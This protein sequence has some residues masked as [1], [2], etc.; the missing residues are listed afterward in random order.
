MITGISSPTSSLP[1]L[2]RVH[3]NK[4]Y[5]LFYKYCVVSDKKFLSII[6]SL[7]EKKLLV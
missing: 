4:I 1:S 5:P 7:I 6:D 2:L 3:Y